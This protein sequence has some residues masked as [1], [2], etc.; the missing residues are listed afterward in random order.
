MWDQGLTLKIAETVTGIAEAQK[1][2]PF[3]DRKC[4]AEPE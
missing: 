1:Y 4:P 2:N 3:L